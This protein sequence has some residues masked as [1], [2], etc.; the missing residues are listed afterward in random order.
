M[1]ELS[2]IE[3]N[4]V[5][6]AYSRDMSNGLS[7]LI[8]SAVT[9]AAEAVS[10]VALGAAVGSMAGAVIGGKHGGDGGGLLGVGSIGGALAWSLRVF[11]VAWPAA[12]PQPLLA[13][14]PPRNTPKRPRWA[15]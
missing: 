7:G 1:K 11:W 9:N 12:W 3:M 5:S 14:I 15:D 6:G 13:G 4:E 10:S 2:V 8:G